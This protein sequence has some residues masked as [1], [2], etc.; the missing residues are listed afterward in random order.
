MHLRVSKVKAL[1][2]ARNKANGTLACEAS[3]NAERV[4]AVLCSRAIA[5][6]KVAERRAG[7]RAK[8]AI[9]IAL[10]LINE[11][12]L[13]RAETLAVEANFVEIAYIGAVA[14]VTRADDACKK[15][16]VTFRLETH[17]C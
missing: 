4:G 12:D 6:P 1:L 13:R 16:Q 8:A 9:A 17:F 15:V 7:L 14:V 11:L 5:C 3:D 2:V 10:R